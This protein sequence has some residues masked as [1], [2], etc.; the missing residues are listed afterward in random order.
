MPR[1]QI[2]AEIVDTDSE[3]DG[4]I[5]IETT[6]TPS[7]TEDESEPSMLDLDERPKKNHSTKSSAS[8]PKKKPM[9]PERMAQL[10]AAREAHKKRRNEIKESKAILF[11]KDRGYALT[12]ETKESKEK[13]ESKTIHLGDS[14]RQGTAQVT[15]SVPIPIQ[16]SQVNSATQI[17][18]KPTPKPVLVRQKPYNPFAE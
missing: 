18:S 1:R 7:S 16:S 15:K 3:D 9:T 10:E 12:K 13:A 11:L 14:N 5:R 8:A 2:V 4:R 6:P 17:A